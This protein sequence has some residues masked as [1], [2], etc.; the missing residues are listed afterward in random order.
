[1]F[2]VETIVQVDSVALLLRPS[3]CRRTC[4][5]LCQV[6]PPVPPSLHWVQHDGRLVLLYMIDRSVDWNVAWLRTRFARIRQASRYTAI[7]LRLMLARDFARFGLCEG[8]EGCRHY[9][10][11][12]LPWTSLD[13]WM[14]VL[15]T[16]LL[17]DRLQHVLLD[18]RFTRSENAL[19][20]P[21]L[22]WLT[23]WAVRADCRF[24]FT[25]CATQMRWL[26]WLRRELPWSLVRLAPS[27]VWISLHGHIDADDWWSHYA[28]TLHFTLDIIYNKVQQP[29]LVILHYQPDDCYYLA[30]VIS[31]F[32]AML[33]VRRHG[34]DLP[35]PG[36]QD[37]VILRLD[38]TPWHRARRWHMFGMLI[39]TLY[40]SFA[41]RVMPQC[42]PLV[43][44]PAHAGV[45]RDYMFTPDYFNVE[46]LSHLHCID[47][48]P[49]RWFAPEQRDMRTFK[50]K[51]HQNHVG[52][53]S[54]HKPYR[55][56]MS[57]VAN[58]PDD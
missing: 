8:Y 46:R 44:P 31:L 58:G 5:R 55:C 22:A 34:Q 17:Q 14:R 24:D 35:R 16:M 3:L 10:S 26:R 21:L 47:V 37:Q 20:A 57:S 12:R 36:T 18:V 49:N 39:D 9:R 13:A 29:S 33:N 53:T 23:Q 25:D 1:M 42:P 41:I 7:R 43:L 56:N 51:I 52:L 28:D 15:T 40:K 45:G 48:T 30:E 2:C 50:F 6:P 27:P 32:K 19:S 54:R 4:R 11:A 38:L